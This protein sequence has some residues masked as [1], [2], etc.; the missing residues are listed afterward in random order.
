MNK[1]E[2]NNLLYALGSKY[3]IGKNQRKLFCNVNG[4]NGEYDAGQLTGAC[5]ALELDFAETESTM[6]FSTQ[7]TGKKIFEIRL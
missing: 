7:K 1:E 2:R 3:I 4:D 6:I 5:M